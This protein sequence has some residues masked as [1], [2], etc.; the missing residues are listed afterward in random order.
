M[1]QQLWKRTRKIS[2]YAA[3]RKQ[4]MLNRSRIIQEGHI[5][6]TAW[7]PATT[8]NTF[9]VLP[10]DKQTI[11]ERQYPIRDLTLRD[12]YGTPITEEQYVTEYRHGKP[13]P[14]WQD[15]LDQ[16]QKRK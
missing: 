5:I 1:F 13:F 3:D 4:Q 6:I 12:N 11:K 10:S 9:T 15:P 14:I 2:L 7:Y 16:T 8:D